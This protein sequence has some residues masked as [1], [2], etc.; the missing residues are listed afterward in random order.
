[1][2]QISEIN[3][4]NEKKKKEK[5]EKKEKRKT[6]KDVRLEKGVSGMN[7]ISLKPNCLKNNYHSLFAKINNK[8]FKF[9]RFEIDSGMDFKQL[10]SA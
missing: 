9:L 3:K 10:D 1:M 7:V 4:G 5:N 2:V 8:E 6:N